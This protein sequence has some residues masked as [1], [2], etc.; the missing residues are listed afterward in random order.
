MQKFNRQA[1]NSCYDLRFLCGF[2][3]VCQPESN[4]LAFEIFVN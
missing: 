4:K 3:Y 2:S 1:N